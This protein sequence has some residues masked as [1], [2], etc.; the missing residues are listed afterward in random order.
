[1]ISELSIFSALFIYLRDSGFGKPGDEKVNYKALLFWW[2]FFL[3]KK[4]LQKAGLW[5]NLHQQYLAQIKNAQNN[6]EKANIRIQ[7]KEIVFVKGKELFTWQYIAGICPICTHIWFF[8]SLNNFFV[9]QNFSIF[10][11][12]LLY[13]HLIL[14]ILKK[15]F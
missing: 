13:A 15:Y 10:V 5:N 1:M 11:M 4:A 7:F 12:Q 2:P 9:I 3:S 8:L 6:I 14:R